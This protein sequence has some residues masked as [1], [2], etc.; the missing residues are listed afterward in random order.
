MFFRLVFH[1]VKACIILVNAPSY[2]SK[3][4]GICIGG[5]DISSFHDISHIIFALFF[6][7]SVSLDD[8]MY[9]FCFNSS[10]SS[11]TTLTLKEQLHT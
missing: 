4:L 1:I 9:D 8:C 5:F 7:F 3:L 6:G 11:E 10:T 2:F